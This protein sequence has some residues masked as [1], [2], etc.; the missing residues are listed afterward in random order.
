MT[1]IYH[2]AGK[3]MAENR[4]DDAKN[5]SFCKCNKHSQIERRV[6]TSYATGLEELKT[7]D[8]EQ[9]DCL[10]ELKA[11]KTAEQLDAAEAEWNLSQGKKASAVQQM[12]R[13]KRSGKNGPAPNLHPF[14]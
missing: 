13:A 4:E 9:E 5:N 3:N 6:L 14:F 1:D 11:A 7:R 10:K 12:A 2:P 8:K